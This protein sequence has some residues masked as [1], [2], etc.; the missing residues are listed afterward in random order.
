MECPFCD[1]KMDWPVVSSE[2]YP[3]TACSRGQVFVVNGI[4]FANVAEYLKDQ[5]EEGSRKGNSSAGGI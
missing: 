3:H 2:F 4:V 5:R 1:A